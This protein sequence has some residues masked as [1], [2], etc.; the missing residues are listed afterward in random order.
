MAIPSQG[1]DVTP[2]SGN[3]KL[4]FITALWAVS[5][6]QPAKDFGARSC[7][8]SFRGGGGAFILEAIET[9]EVSQESG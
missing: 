9:T 5:D 8:A 6:G 1:A 3:W 4:H 2:A 7:K